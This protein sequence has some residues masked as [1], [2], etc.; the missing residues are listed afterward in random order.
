MGFSFMTIGKVKDTASMA[1]AYSHNYRTVD[2][3]NADKTKAYLNEELVHLD[4]TYHDAFKN[5]LKEAGIKNYR[6]D[7]VMLLDV[8]TTF[9]RGQYDKIDIEKWKQDQVAWLKETFNKAPDGKDN[10][11]SVMF[12]GDE[13]GNVHCHSMVVPIDERG[14]LSGSSFTGKRAKLINMQNSYGDLMQKNHGLEHGI[15]GS[16]AKHRDIKKF[17]AD[18]NSTKV[19]EAPAV[20]A[21]ETLSSYVKRVKAQWDIYKNQQLNERLEVERKLT[22]SFSRI[23]ERNIS[24]HRENKSLREE[25]SILHEY[26]SIESIKEKL[27]SFEDIK[28]GIERLDEEDRLR[29]EKL[30]DNLEKSGHEEKEIVERI[31]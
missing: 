19:T 26:G 15:R 9:S 6:K 2:V 8:V 20:L 18:L 12:H 5:R 27:E 1:R 13:S 31:D 25:L 11:I 21:G 17:Y 10:V 22:E 4:G 24:L 16:V 30:L 23:N 28:A 3:P 29:C 14:K 7:S